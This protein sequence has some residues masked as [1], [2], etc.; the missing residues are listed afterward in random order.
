M[1]KNILVVD[2]DEETRIFLKKILNSNNFNV[3][4]AI[5]GNEAL[6]AV[7]KFRPDLVLLDFDLQKVTGET[8]VVKIKKNHPGTIIIVLTEK[9]RS[10][11][12]VRGLQIGADDFIS[13]PFVAEELIARIDARLKIS[14]PPIQS[15]PR[16]QSEAQEVD[17]DQEQPQ[18]KIILR[19]SIFLMIVRLISAEIVFGFLLLFLSILSSY[20]STY[21]DTSNLS[22]P[23]LVIIIGIFIINT[24]IV[25]VIAIKWTTEYTE[26]SADGVV[27]R[28][29]IFHK[30]EQKFACNY[31]EGIKLDQTFFGSM[32]NYGTIELYDPALKEKVYLYNVKSPKKN[33][34][35]IQKIVSNK[36]SPAIPF[37]A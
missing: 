14:A 5:D 22:F 26:V 12:I 9:A 16:E 3:E 28:S 6:L 27:K 8:V 13:K 20:I 7:E 25:F 10:A 29:G 23:Y 2:N 31:I 24:W 4:L 19:E 18:T 36:K 33:S 1:K 17:I 34:E 37:V 35:L 21:L 30:K 15:I 32:F 11:D